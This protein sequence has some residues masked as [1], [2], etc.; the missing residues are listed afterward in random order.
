MKGENDILELKWW[1]RRIPEQIKTFTIGRKGQTSASQVKLPLSA[2]QLHQH[3][4]TNHKSESLPPP[5]QSK[6]ADNF[7][8]SIGFS[9]HGFQLILEG[10][11]FIPIAHYVITFVCF[12]LVFIYN[13]LEFHFVEDVLTLFRGSPV[14]LTYNSA[15]E[16]YQ[17]VASKCDL[18][19]G[20][21]LFFSLSI[22]SS[23]LFIG[24]CR[25]NEIC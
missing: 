8:R 20:R 1:F 14:F 11:T 17:G 12:F 25:F 19:H 10:F 7:W 4:F 2:E 16:I 23:L 22:S 15:S 5:V 3:S 13:F 6:M 18:L 21:F 9:V 24:K